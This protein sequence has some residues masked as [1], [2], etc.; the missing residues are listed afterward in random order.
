MKQDDAEEFLR[1]VFGDRLHRVA[2]RDGCVVAYFDKKERK[3][4]DSEFTAADAAALAGLDYG[5]YAMEYDSDSNEEGVL[6][7]RVNTA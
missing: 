7:V 5:V 6:R 3:N 1:A 4:W 2:R